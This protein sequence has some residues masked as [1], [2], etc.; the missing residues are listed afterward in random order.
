M[1]F[2]L[3]K[4]IILRNLYDAWSYA[5]IPKFGKLIVGEEK[6]YKYLVDSIRTFPS[7]EEFSDIILKVGFV[8]NTIR[9][10]TGNIV[11]IYRAEKI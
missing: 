6:P 4:D 2:S 3:P 11:C 8:K 9:Q 5:L 10:L 1:E 7:P